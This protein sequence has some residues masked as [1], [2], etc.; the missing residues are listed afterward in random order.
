M[1]PLLFTLDL[2]V[3]LLRFLIK[4]MRVRAIMHKA[5]PP[6]QFN[7]SGLWFNQWTQLNDESI[8]IFHCYSL[9][10]CREGN[11]FSK[12]SLAKNNEKFVIFVHNAARLAM[13]TVHFRSR[14]QNNHFV[15]STRE[16]CTGLRLFSVVWSYFQGFTPPTAVVM[17]SK[18]KGKR[19]VV[20][21]DLNKRKLWRKLK[22]KPV[23]KWYEIFPN[24]FD[25]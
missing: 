19:K 9:W 13:C 22:K 3:P 17:P 4:N 8:S 12:Y 20:N 18:R 6:I 25:R 21:Y 7:H 15:V 1:L 11:T 2:P 14:F 10:Y 23:I 24:F 16:L 5:T